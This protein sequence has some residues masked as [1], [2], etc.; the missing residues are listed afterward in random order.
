MRDTV[1]LFVNAANLTR[2]AG[3]EKLKGKWGDCQ[4]TIKR[5]RLGKCKIYWHR[6]GEDQTKWHRKKNAQANKLAEPN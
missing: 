3:R 2:E 6:L 1:C 5:H 4:A